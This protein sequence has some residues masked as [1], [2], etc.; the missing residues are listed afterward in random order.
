[1]I[2]HTFAVRV[3][4]EGWRLL[5]YKPGQTGSDNRARAG[6]WRLYLDGLSL[7]DNFGGGRV[8]HAYLPPGAHWLAAELSNA[9]ST[10]LRPAVWSEPVVLHVPPVIR[11][12][13][14]GWR[15]SPETGTPTFSCNHAARPSTG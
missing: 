9:G 1:V 4:I 7:G 12:W 3:A 11:C 8:T 2:T 15:G 14:T 6:H 10:S 5:P 13:Q